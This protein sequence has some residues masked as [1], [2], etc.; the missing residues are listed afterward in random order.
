MLGYGN[1]QNVAAAVVEGQ[2][3]AESDF[4]ERRTWWPDA[5]QP[6]LEQMAAFDV[7][8]QRPSPSCS[9]LGRSRSGQLESAHDMVS[10][11]LGPGVD[12]GDGPG[13]EIDQGR[14]ER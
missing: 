9:E 6:I 11:R 5:P 12:V 14:V 4:E 2:D 1:L 13:I 7:A 3:L 10:K 8:S